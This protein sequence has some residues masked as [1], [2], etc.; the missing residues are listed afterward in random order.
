MDFFDCVGDDLLRVVEE[1]ICLGKLKH[2]INSTFLAMIPKSRYPS[3]F[4][5]FQAHHA[6]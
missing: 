4:D 6:L 2:S 5:E 1:T 3:S